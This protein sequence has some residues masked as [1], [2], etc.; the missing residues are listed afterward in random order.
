MFFSLYVVTVKLVEG[1]MMEEEEEEGWERRMSAGEGGGGWDRRWVDWR[2]SHMVRDGAWVG[3]GRNLKLRGDRK[4]GLRKEKWRL[5]GYKKRG[6]EDGILQ[7]KE[8][9]LRF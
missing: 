7:R 1:D 6:R 9:S 5:W 4:A 8:R 2:W 3:R